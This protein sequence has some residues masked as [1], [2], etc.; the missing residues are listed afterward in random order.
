V[1]ERGARAG[2]R[3][4]QYAREGPAMPPPVM[5]IFTGV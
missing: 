3:V 2:I 5:R 4:S 1:I